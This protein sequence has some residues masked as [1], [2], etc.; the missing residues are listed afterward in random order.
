[1]QGNDAHF[2]NI[3]RRGF[4]CEKEKN[5]DKKGY[6]LLGDPFLNKGTAFAQRSVGRSG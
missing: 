1:M 3:D 5:M 4:I 6:E 2:P